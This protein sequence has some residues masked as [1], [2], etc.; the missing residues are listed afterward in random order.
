MNALGTHLLAEL[1]D[2]DRDRLD[3]LSFIRE[4]MLAAA[5]AVGATILSDT[6]HQFSPQG[7]TGIIAIA[8]S[9]LSIHTWPEYGYAA[10]DIFTCG[11]SFVPAKAAELIIQR[12]GCKD[13]EITEIKRGKLPAY[14]L[15][16]ATSGKAG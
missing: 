2:C 7:V 12:L 5:R 6:F 4:S 14:A 3:N 13:P 9:H 1:R 16:R 10:V 15:E 8:E 11:S